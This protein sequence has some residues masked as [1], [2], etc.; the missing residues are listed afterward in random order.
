MHASQI[1]FLWDQ[2]PPRYLP[3]YHYVSWQLTDLKQNRTLARIATGIGLLLTN[4]LETCPPFY[5]P[6]CHYCTPRSH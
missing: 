1:V 5:W 6:E 2:L 3:Q 4:E